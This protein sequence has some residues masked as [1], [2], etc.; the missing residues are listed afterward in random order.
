MKRSHLLNLISVIAALLLIINWI[1][2]AVGTLCFNWFDY[3]TSFG[4][5]FFNMAINI[6]AVLED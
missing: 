1:S 2:R 5:L 4:T 3:S 6:F